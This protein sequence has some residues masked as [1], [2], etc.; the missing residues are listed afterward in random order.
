MANSNRP[1][2]NYKARLKR[3]RKEAKRFLARRT[4]S[5]QESGTRPAPAISCTKK[6]LALG[7][8]LLSR[9]I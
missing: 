1:R 2:E 6:M 7:E 9:D 5:N 4:A 8:S 3:R